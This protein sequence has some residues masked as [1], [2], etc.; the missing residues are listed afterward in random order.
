MIN[1]GMQDQNFRKK[2]DLTMVKK[3]N[4]TYRRKETTNKSIYFDVNEKYSTCASR[5]KEN[6]INVL[7]IEYI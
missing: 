3:T 1:V 4:T 6:M 7:D 2:K 5:T